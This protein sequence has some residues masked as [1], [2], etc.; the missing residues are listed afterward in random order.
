M[1]TVNRWLTLLVVLLLLAA[2]LGAALA[3]GPTATG[4]T[5]PPGRSGTAPCWPPRTREATAFVNLRYDRGR[6]GIDAVAAGA[7]GDFRDA[8]RAL[9]PP[10]RPRSCSASGRC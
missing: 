7:T 3:G 8:L 1:S 6:R 9:G 5:P 4:P 2:G 10:A